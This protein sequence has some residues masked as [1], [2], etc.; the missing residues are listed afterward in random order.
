MP[1]IVAYLSIIF[2]RDLSFYKREGHFMNFEQNPFG[3]GLTIL[4]ICLLLQLRRKRPERYSGL[5]LFSLA[6]N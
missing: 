1:T 5:F 6:C 4:N 3:M 2:K